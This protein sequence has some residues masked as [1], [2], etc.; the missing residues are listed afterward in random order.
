VVDA[1]GRDAAMA[2][3]RGGTKRVPGLENTAFYTQYRGA[4]RAEGERKGDIIIPLVDGG[5]FWFIPFKDGRTS[6]G[7]VMQKRWT[8][9]Y[10]GE[11]P[12]ALFARA[13]SMSTALQKLVDGAEQI[14]PPGAVADFTF[15]SREMAGRSWLAVGDSA[16]FID[17]LFSSG[18]H[19][20]MIGAHRGADTLHALLDGE[21][22]GADDVAPYA[23][24]MKRG[25]QLFIGMVQS[26]YG[27][28]LIPYL[29]AENKREY[30]TRAITSMLAGDV[31]E[32][33][34]WSNDILT[35]FPAQLET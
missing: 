28:V 29:F 9:N 20:A 31:F 10:A 18:A 12:P 26:F 34:R 32:E 14:F 11:S 16:G 3:V 4:Y 6:V 5:W 21:T 7:A 2:R 15:L 13:L 17:P 25:T 30:L 27:G 22:F 8:K 33:A 35:R 1:T 19:V 24:T 23:K